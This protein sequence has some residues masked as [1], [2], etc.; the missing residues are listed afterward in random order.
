MIRFGVGVR[1]RRAVEIKSIDLDYF[2]E[3]E[4]T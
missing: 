1:L 4:L 2:E 3:A